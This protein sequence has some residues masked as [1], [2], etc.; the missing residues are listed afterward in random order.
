M[1]IPELRGA[2]MKVDSR[3]WRGEWWRLLTS[4]FV[5]GGATHLVMSSYTLLNS[6]RQ[7]RLLRIDCV[8]VVADFASL[9]HVRID[10]TKC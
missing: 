7:V 9:Q 1:Q 2:L 8:D 4:L 5:H 10:L 3:I 6:G